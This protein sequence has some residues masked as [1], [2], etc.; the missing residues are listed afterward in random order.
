MGRVEPGAHILSDG[1]HGYRRLKEK[2]FEHTATALSKQ[3]QDAHI[4][5]PGARIPLSNL[6]RFL[7]G[8]HHKVQSQQL[9]RYAAE[10]N[11]RLNRRTMKPDLTIRTSRSASSAPASA[12]KP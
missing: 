1:R 11:Y 12:P 4:L 8:T 5:F 9:K 6:K 7:L 3:E 2:G 10:F